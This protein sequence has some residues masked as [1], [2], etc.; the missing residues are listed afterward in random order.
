MPFRHHFLSSENK[1][2]IELI[3]HKKQNKVSRDLDKN[4]LSA[5]ISVYGRYNYCTYKHLASCHK[6]K[7]MKSFFLT[8][9]FL[10]NK[11]V[12]EVK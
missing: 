2:S 8:M 11:S 1:F 10:K 12:I 7:P 4:F 3:R 5:G 6:N 9:L